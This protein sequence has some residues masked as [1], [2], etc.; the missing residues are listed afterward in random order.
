M[1][2]PQ[3]NLGEELERAGLTGAMLRMKEASLYYCL[4]RIDGMVEAYQQKFSQY[5]RPILTYPERKGVVRRFFGWVK[6]SL[7]TIN[8]VLG[9]LPDVLPGK[10]ILK[11]FKEHLES[12]YAV[13]EQLAEQEEN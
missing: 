3:P 6:A 5:D 13:A 12:G 7:P 8:S 2:V 10:E 1:A 9:S 11:E 4:N